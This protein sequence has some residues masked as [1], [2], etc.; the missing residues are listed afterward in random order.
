MLGDQDHA[1]KS[2]YEDY[3]SRP[4][5]PLDKNVLNKQLSEFTEVPLEEMEKLK[6][7]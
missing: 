6:I 5:K 1:N 4:I 3:D 2:R 7:R